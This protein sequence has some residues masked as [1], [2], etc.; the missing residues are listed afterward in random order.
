MK[1]RILTGLIGGIGFI[2]L[3]WLG[4]LPYTILVILLALIGYYE[5]LRMN[6]TPVFSWQGLIGLNTV[7]FIILTQ[8][9]LLAGIDRQQ[10]MSLLLVSLFLYL[11]LIVIK[12]N[13][14]NFDQVSY[15]LFGAMYIGFGFSYMLETRLMEHGFQFSLLVFLATFA[16]DSGAYFTGK[17]L[18]KTKLWPEISPKK[19]IEGSI[20]GIV[21]AIIV[22]LLLNAMFQITEHFMLMIWAGI[23]IAITG[24]FGDLIESALKRSKGVK[25]SGSLLPGHGGVLDRFDS[26]IF[27]FPILHLLHIL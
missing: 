7:L 22:S 4:E 6:Q 1:Q 13:E 21:F 15:H 20:G 17:Y 5:F 10:L 18:G 19:T 11:A 3:V 27:V 23:L 26:L 2:Y 25:D 16:S 24:Q 12:K 14:I 9:S 8:N